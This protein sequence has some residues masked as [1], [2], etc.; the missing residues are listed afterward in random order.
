MS[1]MDHKGAS[2]Q[3]CHLETQAAR[4]F[5]STSASAITKIGKEDEARH[6]LTL[7]A[8]IPE[9]HILLVLTLRNS[10]RG[11]ILGGVTQ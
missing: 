11:Q 7:E 10:P 6:I 1:N 9:R 3:R 5:I 2:A 8:S 4:S